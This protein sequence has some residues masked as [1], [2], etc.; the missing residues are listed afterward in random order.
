M[1]GVISAWGA[2]WQTSY[3]TILTIVKLKLEQQDNDEDPEPCVVVSHSSHGRLIED[4][5]RLCVL[6]GYF[7]PL[8]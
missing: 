3:G 5:L 1:S 7:V 8:E 2:K 4:D 6:Q